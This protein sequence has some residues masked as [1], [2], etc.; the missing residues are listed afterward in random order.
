M[1]INCLDYLMKIKLCC[2]QMLEYVSLSVKLI[3]NNVN[4]QKI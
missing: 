2:H 3:T 4:Y 1:R